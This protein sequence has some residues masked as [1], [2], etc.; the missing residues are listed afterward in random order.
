MYESSINNIPSSA[1]ILR[2]VFDFLP[3]GVSVNWLTGMPS[4]SNAEASPEKFSSS[5]LPGV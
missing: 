5:L 1:G 4:S 2:G 3:E